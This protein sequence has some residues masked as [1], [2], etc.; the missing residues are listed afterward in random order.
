MKYSV[1]KNTPEDTTIIQQD[2]FISSGLAGAPALHLHLNLNTADSTFNGSAHITQAT[3][4]P[5]QFT[6]MVSGKYIT[7]LE[8]ATPVEIFTGVGNLLNTPI[9]ENL[10]FSFELGD[11][12]LARFKYRTS[13]TS[14][15]VVIEDA[16]V[17]TVRK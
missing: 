3:N 7:I 14:E 8:Q 17:E 9:Y 2:F 12:N 10:D 16:R 13:M 1:D 4:P 15:W 5:P 11:G 6:S